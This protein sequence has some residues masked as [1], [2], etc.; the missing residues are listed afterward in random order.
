[1]MAVTLLAQ[2][3]QHGMRT[4]KYADHDNLFR[5]ID[6]NKLGSKCFTFQKEC[7]C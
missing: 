3:K 6:V 2:R 7:G 4:Y 1:M 5:Y